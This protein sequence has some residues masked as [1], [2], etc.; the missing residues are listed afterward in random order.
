MPPYAG[1]SP[2]SE[3]HHRTETIIKQRFEA[4]RITLGFEPI[5]LRDLKRVSRINDVQDRDYVLK[6]AVSEFI[7]YDLTIK[8][9]DSKNI[10]KVFTQPYMNEEDNI[11][12]YAQFDSIATVNSI[13]Q[14]VR[15][16]SEKE[17]HRVMSYYPGTH[18]EQLKYLK[19]VEYPYRKPQPGY[20]KCSTRGMFGHSNLYLQYKPPGRNYWTTIPTPDLPPP[21]L[22]AS[23]SSSP[24]VGKQRDLAP[25]SSK[26]GASC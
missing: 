23:P 18:Q 1:R 10:V 20:E 25:E 14:H 3:A 19:D 5:D 7:R 12:I 22:R 13:W 15:K 16:L 24:P 2:P 26:R 17:D 4:G 9:V 8:T 21:E 6:L 11:R